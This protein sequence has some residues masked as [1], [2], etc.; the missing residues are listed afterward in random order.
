MKLIFRT[1]REDLKLL[2]FISE[3]LDFTQ[4]ELN[5]F[6]DKENCVIKMEDATFCE[7]F[8]FV[9]NLF[10]SYPSKD[11]VTFP[12]GSTLMYYKKGDDIYIDLADQSE[13]RS[14][15]E[16]NP[17]YGLDVDDFDI[18]SGNYLIS[19]KSPGSFYCYQL[20]GNPYI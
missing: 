16:T 7:I 8:N 6:G 5:C 14:A 15:D 10:Y 12:M 19:I 11:N 20:D 4:F 9:D 18:N 2:N 17:P 1:R 13:I 3:E